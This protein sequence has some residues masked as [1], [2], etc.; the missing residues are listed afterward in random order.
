MDLMREGTL[1]STPRRLSPSMINGNWSL[2]CQR[3][4]VNRNYSIHG[5]EIQIL[6]TGKS[7]ASKVKI[8]LVVGALAGSWHRKTLMAYPSQSFRYVSM[9]HWL[10]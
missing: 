7:S 9:C 10:D 5:L 1:G 2:P 6:A 3:F 4:W 8:T